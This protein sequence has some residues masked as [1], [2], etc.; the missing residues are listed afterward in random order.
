MSIL[1]TYVLMVAIVLRGML[2]FFLTKRP[3]GIF[4]LILFIPT[5]F[6]FVFAFFR[7]KENLEKDL[8]HDDEWL[9]NKYKYQNPKVKG[10]SRNKYIPRV[11]FLSVLCACSILLGAITGGISFSQKPLLESNLKQITGQFDYIRKVSDDY[12]IGLIGDGTEYRIGSVE[13]GHF[14]KDFIK[15]ISV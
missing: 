10:Y 9:G 11:L 8:E 1:T 15:E 12:A 13:I 6:I 5:S 2:L 4:I 7:V 14:D 3:A